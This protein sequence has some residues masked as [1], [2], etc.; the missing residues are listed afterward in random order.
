MYELDEMEIS[1]AIYPVFSP[2]LFTP[3]YESDETGHTAPDISVLIP[4][5]SAPLGNLNEIG[6]MPYTISF[7][8]HKGAKNQ[9]LRMKILGAM[10]LI[11]SKQDE[12]RASI[13]GP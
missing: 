10:S 13:H 4:W 11:S 7:S 3:L 1:G 12:P 6:C 5:F 2:W 8:S 9:G